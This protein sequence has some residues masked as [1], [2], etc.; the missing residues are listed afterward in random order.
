MFPGGDYRRGRKYVNPAILPF[1]AAGGEIKNH[2]TEDAM[3]HAA[4]RPASRFVFVLLERFT[5]LPFSGAIECLRLSNR[6]AGQQIYD[7]QIVSADGSAVACS[8]G[9]EI[10]VNSGLPALNR[11]DIAVICGGLD[12]QLHSPQA[13]INWLRRERRKGVRMVGLCTGAVPLAMAGLLRGRRATIHWENHDGFAE[14]FPEVELTRSVFIQDGPIATAAGGTASLDLML[15]LIT[16]DHGADLAHA[17]ADQ[18]IYASI[19]TDADTQ[20]LSIPTR[21]GVRHPKLSAVIARME[22]NIEDPVS[23]PTLAAEVGLS[24]RQLERLFRRYVERSPKRYYLELRLGRA[25]NLLMQTQMSVIDVALACGFTSPSHF[26]KC[27]RTH[28]GTTPY[29]ERGAHARSPAL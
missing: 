21:I 15:T 28:Y 5:L 22:A 19:R 8:S 18:L 7:W 2:A 17:V 23:P 27:Y 12:A 6:L 9:I 14:A 11:D 1:W 24:T 10:A 4:P 16:E 3:P 29:R 26:S 25:R 13:L 20:R